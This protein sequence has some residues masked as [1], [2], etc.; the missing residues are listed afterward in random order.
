M[1][2]DLG[3]SGPANQKPS[4]KNDIFGVLPYVAPEVLNKKSYTQKSD[5]YSFGIL[6]SETSTCQQPFKD[7]PH[8][9]DLAFKICGGLRPSFSDNTPECYIKLAY[10][11][12]DADPEKRPTADEI[13]KILAFWK[14]A[15]DKYQSNWPNYSEEQL[16]ELKEMRKIFDEADKKPFN[17]ST[18]T[19]TVHPNAVYTSRLLNFTNLP[20]PVNSNTVTI[21]SNNDGN[22]LIN[23]KIQ[24][25]YQY[26]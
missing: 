10:R 11:C 1:I 20:Q 3:L 6:M 26:Y 21:I 5:I 15:I 18:I 8:D 14:D 7:Q 16:Y 25:Q 19:A 17:P 12:M 22:Y 9:L 2:T 13:L 24:Y 23:F 4:S